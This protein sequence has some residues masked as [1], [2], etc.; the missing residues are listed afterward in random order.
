ML[1]PL[2]DIFHLKKYYP[3]C[4]GLFNKS[5]EPVRAVDGVDLQIFSGE[6]VALV[7]ESGSGKTTLA[8]CLFRITKP[9]AG[10]IRFQGEEV[11]AMPKKDLQRFRRQAQV[12]FQDADAALNPRLSVGR[13]IAEP[14]IAHRML[15]KKKAHQRAAELLRQVGLSEHYFSALPNELSC[16]QRHRVVIARALALQPKFL[17]ADE[18]FSS[19]DVLA[20]SRLL[21]LFVALQKQFN[22]TYFFISHDLDLVRQICHRVFVMRQGK[23]VDVQTAPP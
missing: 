6:T 11:W 15:E 12:I 17:A 5:K 10:G 7:G 18:P 16:G 3:R 20:K 8:Q 1:Q 13:V 22:L 2:I 21:D 19:L 14:L 9:S 23:I 4:N